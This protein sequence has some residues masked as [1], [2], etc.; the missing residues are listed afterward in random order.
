MATWP[1]FVILA[2]FTVMEAKVNRFTLASR[3][4]LLCL[5]LTLLYF[6]AW[7]ASAY[8]ISPQLLC[9]GIPL[10]FLLSCMVMPLLFIILCA[11][12][13]NHLFVDVSLDATEEPHEN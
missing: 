12:M 13:L 9:L 5:G 11:L 4:A 8:R 1:F 3:E 2:P 10:W 7:Y 6:V